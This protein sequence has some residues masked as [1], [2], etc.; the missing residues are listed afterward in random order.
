MALKLLKVSVVLEVKADRSD[1]EDL[2]ER[3]YDQLQ[4]LVESDEL[5]FSLDEDEEEIE[6]ES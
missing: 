6:D 1:P 2:R 3:V 4:M 5:E